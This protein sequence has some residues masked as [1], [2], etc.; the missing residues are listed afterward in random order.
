M[1]RGAWRATVYGA[2]KTWTRL[3]AHAHTHTHTRMYK[4]LFIS[5]YTIVYISFLSYV[6]YLIFLS[7]IVFIFDD[8]F[9][10]DKGYPDS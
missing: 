1:D 2:A 10:W 4:T 7:Y 3:S 9:D 5:I 8:Y 6:V